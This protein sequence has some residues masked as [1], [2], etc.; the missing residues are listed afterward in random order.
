M[1]S[2]N[3][4][5]TVAIGAALIAG[6]L[7]AAVTYV[8]CIRPRWRRYVADIGHHLLNVVEGLTRR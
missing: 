2:S 8:L 6:A 3:R 7:A 1:T 4:K 5:Q